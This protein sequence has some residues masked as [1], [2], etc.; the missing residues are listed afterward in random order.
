MK[1]VP[2]EGATRR[3]ARLSGATYRL[4]VNPGFTLREAAGLVD[5][6]ERLGITDLYLS[7]IFAAQKGSPHGYN[8]TDHGRINPEIG[9]ESAFEELGHALAAR[10][11]GLIL[12]LVP[13]HMGIGDETNRYWWDVLENGPSSPHASFF[14]IDWAPPK[15][16]LENQILLP[17]LGDQYGIVLEAGQLQLRHADGAF[18]VHYYERSFPL[19]PKS[20]LRILE[21]LLEE[22]RPTAPADDPALIEIESII[23]QIRNLPPRTEKDA[24][25]LRERRREQDVARRRLATLVETHPAFLAALDA[26]VTRLNGTPGDPASFDALDVILADQVYRLS[27][28]RVAADE[29]NYRRFFDVNELAAIRV[30]ESEVFDAAHDLVFRQVGAGLVSGLRIDHIDGLYNPER[31]LTDL[32]EGCRRALGGALVGTFPVYVEKILETDERLRLSWLTHGTVGYEFMNALNGLFVDRDHAAL[33]VGLYRRFA[34][35]GPLF[36]EIV[37]SSKKLIMLISLA[38]EL[39]VLARQLDQISEQHRWSRD[40]TAENLRF[41]LREVI[42]AF[43]VYRSY[44]RAHDHLIDPED[45]RHVEAAIREAKRRNPATSPSI[46]DFIASVILHADPPRLGEAAIRARREF[47]MKFQQLT[48]P[49]MAK[50]VEDT[51]FYRWYAL[52]SLN[53]VGGDPRRFGMAREEFHRRIEERRAAW[54]RAMVATSTHDAKR[55]EDVRARLNVLSE[56]PAEW[57]AAIGRW[58]EMNR[59]LRFENEEG[60]TPD[61]N[62]EYLLYMTLLGTWPFAPMDDADHEMYLDRIAAYMEKALKEAK[63]RTSWIKPNEEHDAAVRAFVRGILDRANPA[64]IFLPDFIAFQEPI[65]LA[66]TWN[67]LGQALFKCAAPGVPDFYQGSEFWNFSLVDPDNRRPVDYAS[68]RAAL[69]EILAEGRGGTSVLGGDRMSQIAEGEQDRAG[70]FGRLLADPRDPRLKLFVIQRALDLRRRRRELFASGTYIPLTVVGPRERHVVAFARLDGEKAVL[71][72][73]GR[74]LLGLDR[75]GR[76]VTGPT[77]QRTF[78]ILPPELAG[79]YRDV[80]SGEDLK[81]TARKETVRLPLDRLFARAPFALL[82][83]PTPESEA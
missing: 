8:V 54:P 83:R 71:A 12:D 50:G 18:T 34:E 40:Y 41:A 35:V 7:P 74:F 19:A 27:Y 55:G 39:N 62:E 78:L 57:E 31:Y 60:V 10:R 82:E 65:A 30:E 29:I 69:D 2:A 24:D 76:R 17:V 46:F 11:M 26:F 4:Q 58:R 9:G 42:A 52:P 15:T 47:T 75:A 53:E 5:Y 32:Q 38:S 23:T 61:G 6:F 77:W 66:G 80:M 81:S 64:N 20:I 16:D 28:W 36:R 63:L 13:N 3:E 56:I 67:G 1:P 79:S 73:T 14:D 22:L 43:P 37:H 25:R 21:P 68:R 49:V 48:A 59:G 51:A 72:V 44:I 70:L 33:F 45:L